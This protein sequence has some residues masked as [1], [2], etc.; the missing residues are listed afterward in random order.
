MKKYIFSITAISLIFTFFSCKSQPQ[1]DKFIDLVKE[2]RN[3]EA[4]DRF[5]YKDDINETDE[6]LNTAV[7][8]AAMNKDKD[9]LEFL[10]YKGAKTNLK[11]FD[12][13][14]P[15]HLA[16]DN[17]SFECAGILSQIGENIFDVDEETG[18]IAF[19]KGFKKNEEYYNLFITEKTGKLKYLNRRTLVHYFAENADE[20]GIEICKERKIYISPKDNQGLTP[21]DLAFKNADNSKSA[22]IA[23]FLIMAGAEHVTT[24][25]SYFQDA[26][27]NRNLNMRFDDGQTPL[28]IASILGHA[29]IVNYLLENNAKVDIQD[30]IGTTPLHEA[31]RY[32]NVEIVKMILNAGGNVNAKDNLGKTPILLAIPQEKA[33]EIYKTLLQFRADASVK[34]MYGDTALHI[35]TMTNAPVQ[36][37]QE[38]VSGGAEINDRNKEGVTPL[39]VALQNHNLAHVQFYAS[40][41]ADIHSQDNSGNSPLKI[42]LDSKDNEI[43]TVINKY[44]VDTRDSAGNTPLHVAILKDSNLAKIQVI[45]SLT[46]DVNQ[47]NSEGNTALYIAIIKNR[48][49]LGKLLLAKNADIFSTNNINYSP[50]RLALKAGGSV[51]EW[52]ITPQTI[53]QTDGSGNSVLH[54]AAE[55]EVLDAIEP[56]ISKGATCQIT[57]ANGETPLFNAVKTNNAELVELL[58]K[59]GCKINQ[60]DNLGS[61]PLHFAV[62]WDAP[63]SINKL[64]ELGANLN[65]QNSSGKSPLAEAVLGGK[66]E[67]ANLLLSSG[68]DSNSSDIT[69]RTILMDAIRGQN[70]EVVKLLLKNNA[71]VNIQETNGR[72]SYHDAALTGNVEIIKIIRNAGGNPLSRDKNGNTPFSLSLSFD[73]NVMKEVLGTNKNVQ[74][75]D[76]NTPVHIVVKNNGRISDLQFLI[77]S[78]YPIDIRN[79]EGF[80]PLGIAINDDNVEFAEILLK[81]KAN[82]FI[83]IDKKGNSPVSIA[84]KKSNQKMLSNIVKYSG[85]QTDIQ[86]NSILHYAARISEPSVVKSLISYGLDP[87]VKNNSGETPYDIAVRWNKKQ[88]AGILSNSN[89]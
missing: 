60:R 25:F 4:K 27:S 23:A 47:R 63:N 81:N 65:A 52:L 9:L 55:W 14:T 74:D 83:S 19:E 85:N 20:L 66:F 13:K 48:E 72:N 82:P 7:H 15:L 32:G 50:L 56:L 78:K 43:E 84:L 2:N 26:V 38:L 11:N 80:T 35:A 18:E 39:L 86:G 62:R 3:Q 17:D 71:Y 45:L 29:G 73:Q 70:P 36:V 88:V 30:S 75:S 8:V 61:T 37:L 42:A 21:L 54:Y 59:K 46:N 68:A 16:I 33:L 31:V 69:G 5:T 22:E 40:H 34:D 79:S 12:G 49:Q 28:H 41:G 87:N 1:R 67:I 89:E 53:K 24:E 51:M 57:N 58:V 76:G 44:N 77:D 6:N 10:I 64:I